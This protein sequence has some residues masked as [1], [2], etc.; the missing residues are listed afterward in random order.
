MKYAT[1]LS[2]L[3]AG[4]LV[5]GMAHASIDACWEQASERYNIPVSMLKAIAKTESNF[6]PRAVNRNTDGSE[7]IGLVQINSMHLP[8][9]QKF[10][11]DRNALFDPCT[12][13]MTG[14]WILSSN[15]AK[16]GWNWN[17]IGSYNVGCKNLPAAECARRREMYAQKIHVALRKVTDVTLAPAPIIY[18]P[19]DMGSIKVVPLKSDA[20][21][22]VMSSDQKRILAVMVDDESND[23]Y[24]S[25]GHDWYQ[26]SG[27]GEMDDGE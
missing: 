7:D 21:T 22:G 24:T 11:I 2:L 27:V 18:V 5:F 14:A 16:L 13:L 26:S 1:T 3:V 9:L 12:N 8:L 20:N 15:V 10:G 23:W 4:S 17:A 19:T 6:N 25:E